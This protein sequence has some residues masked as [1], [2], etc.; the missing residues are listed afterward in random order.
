MDV[1]YPVEDEL[2]EEWDWESARPTGRV[3]S[4]ARAHRE[5][6]PHEGVHL[7][8][9]RNSG[10]DAELLFQHRAAFKEM[11]PGCYDITV[12]GHVPFGWNENKIQK[13]ADEEL[14]ISPSD[15]QLVDLGYFRYEEKNEWLFHRELQRVYLL[16]DNR[17]LNRYTFRDGEVDGIC[18]VPIAG[19]VSLFRADGILEAEAFDGSSSRRIQISRADFHP[20]LFAPSMERYVD[21]LLTAV[22]EYASGGR[23]SVKMPSPV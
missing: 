23:V 20:L 15:D 21:V 1:T 9:V 11:Y 4:R 2:L 13:E 16:P 7:W 18:A 22:R 8:I 3:I 19:L 6:V 10:A 5:G 12:G 14:G 17:E